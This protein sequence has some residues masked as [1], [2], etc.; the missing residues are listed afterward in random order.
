[1]LARKLC[2]LLNQTKAAT[3]MTNVV[4]KLGIT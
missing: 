4:F 2:Q 3:E 1:M